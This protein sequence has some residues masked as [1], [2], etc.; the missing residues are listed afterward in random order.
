M[1]GIRK[2]HDLGVPTKRPNDYFAEMVKSDQHMDKAFL[3][4][5]N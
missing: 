4:F 2:L 1:E 3:F 5:D